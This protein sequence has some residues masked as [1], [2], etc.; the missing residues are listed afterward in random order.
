VIA[1]VGDPQDLFERGNSLIDRLA[2]LAQFTSGENQ[3]V[4]W[5]IAVTG[6]L[7]AQRCQRVECLAGLVGGLF[8][9]I[10]LPAPKPQNRY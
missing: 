3:C 7:H 8:Y 2:G 9:R 5:Y 4:R 1:F 10:H 6:Q